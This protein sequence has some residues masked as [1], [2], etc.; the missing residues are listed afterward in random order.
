M[1]GSGDDDNF[2]S[3]EVVLLVGALVAF[4]VLVQVGVV[5]RIGDWLAHLMTNGVPLP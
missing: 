3:S 5:G 2:F 4:V 1:S